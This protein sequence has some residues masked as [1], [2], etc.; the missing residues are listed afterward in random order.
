MS[1]V[2]VDW[3]E[4]FLPGNVRRRG[5]RLQSSGCMQRDALVAHRIERVVVALV[6]YHQQCSH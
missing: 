1:G 5:Q 3:S 2:V 6:G 4:V